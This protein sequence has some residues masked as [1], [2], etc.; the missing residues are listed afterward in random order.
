MILWKIGAGKSH[1]SRYDASCSGVG[2]NR[3]S[4][5]DDRRAGDKGQKKHVNLKDVKLD[6]KVDCWNFCD[7]HFASDCTKSA[8]K[9]GDK[10]WKIVNT[11]F[12]DGYGDG[13][14]LTCFENRLPENLETCDDID[15]SDAE[16]EI[17]NHS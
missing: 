11:T 9:D 12:R 14:I 6:R 2:F 16:L 1:S 8:K 7:N 10:R 3:A 15:M 13:V 4:E 5:G 17:G